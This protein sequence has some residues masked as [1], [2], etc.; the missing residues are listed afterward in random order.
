MYCQT[1]LYKFNLTRKTIKVAPLLSPI[2]I[3]D[4]LC[5]CRRQNDRYPYQCDI[6]YFCTTFFVQ[7]GLFAS[8]VTDKKSS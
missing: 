4:F 5:Q 3:C 7:L 8:R 6:L 2:Y 1:L